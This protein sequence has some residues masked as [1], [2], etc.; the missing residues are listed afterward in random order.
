MCIAMGWHFVLLPAASAM[1]VPVFPCAAPLLPARH[2]CPFFSLC[3]SFI[4]SPPVKAPQE[5]AVFL[6]RK[7]EAHPATANESVGD[8][9]LPPVNGPIQTLQAMDSPANSYVS[10]RSF[11]R[12]NSA[13]LANC[14][15]DSGVR[16]RWPRVA[17]QTRPHSQI[18]VPAGPGE[19]GGYGQHGCR[20]TRRL[21]E[22]APFAYFRVVSKVREWLLEGTETV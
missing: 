1:P 2:E 6:C 5:A 11:G 10:S 15:H 21:I 20:L 19:P 12:L 8:A 14:N 4:E 13:N 17:R 3:S 22:V 7:H 16:D 9:R 18:Q